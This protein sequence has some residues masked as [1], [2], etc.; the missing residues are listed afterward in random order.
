MTAPLAVPMSAPIELRRWP[1]E[2][3]R[4]ALVALFAVLIWV[5]LVVSVVGLIYAVLLGIFFFLAHTVF[6]AQVRGSGVRLGAAQLPELNE[7]VERMARR[8]GLKKAPEAYLMQAGGALNALATK[9]LGRDCIVLYSDLVD[10]CGDNGAALDFIVAHE[11]AHLRAGHLR[12]RWLLLPGLFM[13]FVGSAWSR[14]CE[15]TA[16]RAALQAAGRGEPALQGLVILAAGGK[17]A[18]RIDTTRLIAQTDSLDTPW[19]KLGQWLSSHPPI[20]RRL[21]ALL[22]LPVRGGRAAALG[23]AG[24]VLLGIGLPSIGGVLLVQQL[25]PQLQAALRPPTAAAPAPAPADERR[26]QVEEGILSLVQ[27]VETARAQGALPA[28]GD[29]L[30]ALWHRHHPG[31]PEPRDPYTGERYGYEASDGHYRLWSP[32]PDPRAVEDDLYYDSR[33]ATR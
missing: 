32:G 28:D 33:L 14:A 30:Y 17:L 4:L 25:G 20:S 9:Y 1:G 24:I 5:L 16:D 22:E 19:M 29:E 13:P 6:I 27:S 7:R 11:L 2:R 18:G 21:A 8:L 3:F 31:L 10:A 12:L 15:H 26:R 23:A